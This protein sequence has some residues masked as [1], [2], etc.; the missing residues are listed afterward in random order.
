MFT[1][2][3]GWAREKSGNV[4]AQAGRKKRWR[5]YKKRKKKWREKEERERKAVKFV[6]A[7]TFV[8]YWPLIWKGF[9]VLRTLSELKWENICHFNFIFFGNFTFFF[10]IFMWGD[11][12]LN[13]YHE[14]FQLILDSTSMISVAWAIK[15]NKKLALFLSHL[16]IIIHIR[17][18]LFNNYF[19]RLYIQL[20]LG[21]S[22]L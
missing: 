11:Q 17:S 21:L 14:V 19:Q 4:A 10:S 20:I 2:V 15:K 5:I 22:F 9:T 7:V 6:I 3:I 18:V 13:V 8:L 1:R 16:Q 12:L